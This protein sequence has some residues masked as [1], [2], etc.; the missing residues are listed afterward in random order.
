MDII[1][2]LPIL[3][4]ICIYYYSSYHEKMFNKSIN[5][6]N[7][8]HHKLMEYIYNTYN[9][10]YPDSEVYDIMIMSEFLGKQY[11]ANETIDFIDIIQ[12]IDEYI[13]NHL[14]NYSTTTSVISLSPHPLESYVVIDHMNIISIINLYRF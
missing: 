14:D 9:D 6:P 3:A 4:N 5:I 11:K 7:N 12:V 1:N 13:D 10:I 8:V 2:I